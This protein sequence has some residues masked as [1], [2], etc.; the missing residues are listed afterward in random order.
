M[1]DVPPKVRFE[2]LKS[3]DFRVIHADGV[4]GGLTPHGQLFISFFSERYPIPTATVFQL[5]PGGNLGPEVR[6]EREGRKG[7]IREIEAGVMVDVETARVIVDWLQ[8]KIQEAEK[9]QGPRKVENGEKENI[10]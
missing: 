3:P 7:I 10:Q 2:Y 1:A 6:T 8:G 5:E 9:R 4:Y